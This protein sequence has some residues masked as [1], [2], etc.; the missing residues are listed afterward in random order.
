MCVCL[1]S[2]FS[3]VGLFVN[4]W[5]KAHQA[6]LSM[7]FSKQEDWSGTFSSRGSSRPRDQALVSYLQW[8]GES[9]P[10]VLPGNPLD[11]WFSLSN[12][13]TFQESVN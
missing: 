9:L 5:T 8:Q 4:L 11:D 3:H 6:P 12:P 10:L 13:L 1:L 2:H 7:G